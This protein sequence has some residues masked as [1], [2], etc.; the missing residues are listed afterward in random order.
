MKMKL[1]LPINFDF[2]LLSES[3]KLLS[4]H[5]PEDK[6]RKDGCFPYRMSTDGATLNQLASTMSPTH[7]VSIG[8]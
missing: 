5:A 4:M 7:L 3:P 1:N 2:K 6:N 8:F